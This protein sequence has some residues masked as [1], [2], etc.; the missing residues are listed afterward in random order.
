MFNILLS[1]K[2]AA[3]IIALLVAYPWLVGSERTITV[4]TAVG[5]DRITFNTIR[6][7]EEQV[8][9][10]I[11]LS[12][13]VSPSNNYLVPESLRLCI[14]GHPEYREC[15][16]RDWTA[17]NFVFNANVNLQKIRDRIKE[18]DE[19]SYP[20]ELRRVVSYL[21]TIQ[22]DNLFFG[23]QLL[24]FVQNENIETLATSFDG[25]DPGQQCSADIAR[26]RANSDKGA[27]YGLAFHDWWNCVNRSL[28]AKVGKYPEADWQEFLR[29]YSIHEK[30]IADDI[31]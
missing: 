26:I 27:A 16:S 18:L 9:R 8:R 31:D 3:R 11:R 24:E 13:N 2:C 30:V 23:S 20:R 17:K 25:I 1:L 4:P 7:S 12:P 15:G 19:S 10:W 14:E 28:R 21:R 29:Q 5:Q 22:E 6:V